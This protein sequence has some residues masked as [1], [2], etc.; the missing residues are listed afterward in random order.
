M[1]CTLR[2]L[3]LIGNESIEKIQVAG[4]ARSV[5]DLLEEMFMCGRFVCRRREETYVGPPLDYR[6]PRSAKVSLV[7]LVITFV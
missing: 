1:S 4:E 3:S 6:S 7:F 2:C 5:R